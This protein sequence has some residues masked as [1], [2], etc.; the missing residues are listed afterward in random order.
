MAIII[1]KFNKQNL[2][3]NQKHKKLKAEIVTTKK[4]YCYKSIET[5]F[6]NFPNP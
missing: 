5:L 1:I 4:S 6:K 3:T 2:N